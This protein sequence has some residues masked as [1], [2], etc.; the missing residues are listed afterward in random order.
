MNTTE[1][2][3]RRLPGRRRGII[4]GAS[5][6]M[7]SDHILLV[8]SAWFREEYKR[9]YLRDIQ[10]IVM[11]PCARFYFSRPMLIF[12]LMWM[13]FALGVLVNVVYTPS[14]GWAFSIAIGWCAS[15]LAMLAVWLGVSLAGS[16]RCR[17]HTA[18]SKDDLP[19]LYRRRT[20]RRFLRR[21]QPLIEQVQGAVPA[22][23]AEAESSVGAPGAAPGTPP[24]IPRI[25]APAQTL[26]ADLFVLSLFAAGIAGLASARAIDAVWFRVNTGLILAQL[27][28]AVI[29]LVQFA[30]GRAA[31][32]MQRLSAAAVVLSAMAFYGQAFAFPYMKGAPVAAKYGVALAMPLPVV[33]F[34]QVNGG[35][36]LL[37][38]TIGAAIV[39]RSL[40][41][42]DPAIIKD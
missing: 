5:L 26:A 4:S 25:D 21:V 6:W 3:Y 11:A 17:L 35:L 2:R 24:P 41:G 33:V 32:A 8:K 15:T 10:A 20:V 7:G 22:G 13:M 42:R 27:A 38:G 31:R 12:A 29:V 18:V 23:W 37:L 36:A 40:F 9:F 19:S 39:I 14:D 34:R 1:E 30:R 16:C 28:G